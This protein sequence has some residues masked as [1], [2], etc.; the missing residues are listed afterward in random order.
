MGVAV[1]V[2]LVF[3]VLTD[4]G[5]IRVALFGLLGT[6]TGA[7]AT[8]E[9]THAVRRRERKVMVRAAGRL[10]QD[11]L[12]FGRV[13]VRHAQQNKRFW[14]PRWDLRLDGW[15]LYRETVAKELNDL[16]DWKRIA[17]AFDTMRSLQGKCTSLRTPTDERP[18]LGPMSRQAMELYMERSNSAMIALAK[19]S[20]DRQS[21]EALIDEEAP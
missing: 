10:L 2:C 18:G 4:Q 9:A 20:G 5:E 1:L 6:L 13:R 8:F 3:A 15:D 17:G 14:A 19:L 16:E 11:D 21:D 7:V 12:A